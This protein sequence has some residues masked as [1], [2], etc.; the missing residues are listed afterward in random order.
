RALAPLRDEGVLIIGSG[1]SYHDLRGFFRDPREVSQTFDAWLQKSVTAEPGQRNE[2]LTEWAQAPAARQAHPRE[3][4]LIPLMVTAGA[5]GQ[6]P[7]TIPYT[8][9]FANAQIT[10]FRFG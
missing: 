2:L 4:H 5:A 3:E 7:A 9:T 1:M 10:A 8:G 6:D